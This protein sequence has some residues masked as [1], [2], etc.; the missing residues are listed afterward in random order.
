MTIQETGVVM[1]ILSTAYPAFY[2]GKTADVKTLR[3]WAEMFAEDDVRLV[4]AAV[5]ALIATKTDSFPPVIGAVKEK[6]RMI[7]KPEEMT[8]LEAWDFVRKALTNS[9]YNSVEEFNKLPPVV[10]AVVHTPE[11]LKDWS[12]MDEATVQSVVASNFQRSYRAKAKAAAEFEALPGE[13]KAMSA[14][15]ASRFALPCEQEKLPPRS[16]MAALDVLKAER[17]SHEVIKRENPVKAARSIYAPMSE[18]DFEKRRAD[19]IRQLK[20]R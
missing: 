18:E 2:K 13:V 8:E 17:A 10:Q 9:A 3:L 19:L 20:E 15:I 5:K 1:D 7:S 14:A 12:R 16:P 4:C 6:I 11:Q